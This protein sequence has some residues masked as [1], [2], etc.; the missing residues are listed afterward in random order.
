MA[1]VQR[2]ASRGRRAETEAHG[3]AAAVVQVSHDGVCTYVVPWVDPSSL[4]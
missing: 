2:V 3:Q 1:A 4:E